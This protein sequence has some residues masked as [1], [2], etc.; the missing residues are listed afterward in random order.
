MATFELLK[1]SYYTDYL[2][3][4]VSECGLMC[5]GAA[6]HCLG[7]TFTVRHLRSIASVSKRGMTASVMATVA[8]QL[9]LSARAVKCDVSLVRDMHVPS[10]LHWNHKHYVVLLA[11]RRG[12][13]RIFDP[14]VGLRTVDERDLDEC[15][16]GVAVEL[17]RSQQFRKVKPA[18]PTG[19]ASVLRALD[20]PKLGVG[21][22][23]LL[24]AVAQLIAL[25][26]PLLMQL[27][28]NR[29]AYRG[30]G[31]LLMV[32]CLAFAAV[33]FI[34]FLVDTWRG[35]LNHR[36]ASQLSWE[37]SR[38][39]FRHMIHLPVA[40]FQRRRLAD[41][42]SRLDSLEPIKQ[43][44]TGGAVVGMVDGLFCLVL[45]VLLFF[46]SPLMASIVAVGVVG[47]ALIK[48]AL[49]PVSTRLSAEAFGARM[50]EQ[51]NR[52]ESFRAIQ[53]IKLAGAERQRELEWS[54]A[55]IH[56]VVSAD[57]LNVVNTISRTSVALLSSLLLVV[58][59]YVAVKQI[60]AGALSIGA[61]FTFAFYRRYF[62]DKT[63]SAVDQMVSMF[64]LRQH[65]ARISEITETASELEHTSPTSGLD[66]L[67]GEV[68]IEG[69]YFRYSSMD[70]YVL[71][72]INASFGAGQFIVI[73]GASGV[74]KSTFLKLLTCLEE[75][76]AGALYFDG[77][78]SEG[79]RLLAL[80]SQIGA[81]MQDDELM[82]GS[83]LENVTAFDD[84]P[85][86]E[87]VRD[88]LRAA[89]VY[90][91][92]MAF[93]MGMDTVVG[94]RGVAIS[95]G[96]RQRIMLARA[97]YKR[98]A[99]LILDEA[100]ANVDVGMERAIHEGLR[101][102]HSTKI[103]VTHRPECAKV[104]DRVFTLTE[105]GLREQARVV[106]VEA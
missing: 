69:V 68:R 104:A 78:R 62:I 66:R 20:I 4:E 14:S 37:F 63:S 30:G 81:V 22:L 3:N 77:V 45:L 60:N 95:G 10:I 36:I 13:Y 96:Q 5:L 101:G 67:A 42:V 83:I 106:E 86:V 38:R 25:A 74:G 33:Y 1:E 32:L 76:S 97:L 80:R 49:Y 102:L 8:S 93:P 9:G 70:K 75:P 19:I 98:P 53:S 52:I 50:A 26:S 11:A 40:W 15:Y 88:A 103:I 100:T 72:G 87:L 7:A 28:V 85:D 46:I 6:A 24:S 2:Q 12:Q 57:R 99:I 27:A 29:A 18:V 39:V 84:A 59:V 21:Q 31:E 105:H 71:S 92:V 55:F 79:A 65:T 54:N 73:V 89:M 82:A 23:V 90:D 58:M 51:S 48:L 41:A 44:L 56:G 43:V 17:Y 91:E 61:A 64:L 94:E 47:N 35:I 16:T 34:G